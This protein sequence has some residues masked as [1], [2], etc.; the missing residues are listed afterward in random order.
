MVSLLPREKQRIVSFSWGRVNKLTNALADRVRSDGVPEIIVA[1]Q[2]GGLIPG[3]IISHRLAV[4]EFLSFDI[5]HTGSDAVN[6]EKVSPRIAL[7]IPF[8]ALVRKDVL[9]VDDIAGTGETFRLACKALLELHPQRIRTLA[10]VVNRDNWDPANTT[11][12]SKWISYIGEEVAAWVV[13]PWEEK[14]CHR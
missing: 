7:H 12:P 6:A 4:R 8:E 5:R 14:V 1:I 10:C 13:F 9:L 3:I 2:R 11:P